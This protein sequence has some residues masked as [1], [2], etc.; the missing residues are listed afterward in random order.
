MFQTILIPLDGTPEA[1]AGLPLATMLAQKPEAKL[2]LL[3]VSSDLNDL[4]AERSARE[5]LEAFAAGL[6]ADGVK[7]ETDF[8][9]GDVAEQIVASAVHHNADLILLT[10]H[11]RHGLLRLWYGSVTED[12]VAKSPIPVLVLR[13]DS[14]SPAQIQTVL[15]PFDDTPGSVAALAIARQIASEPGTA[16]LLARIIPPLPRWGEGW[17]I[18]TDWENT[19]Q[20]SAKAALDGIAAELQSPGRP[21]HTR[22]AVGPI[23]ET[24]T[25]IADDTNADL[26]V[27][28]TRG[29]VGPRR[30]IFGSVADAVVRQAA[31]PVLLVR[32]N[33]ASENT[34]TPERAN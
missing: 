24:I 3:L 30:A 13:A 7:C 34:T 10:T 25:L 27:M 5:Y 29:L 18:N 32:Q 23:A 11:G 31:R 2:V 33:D 28:G 6:T 9:L 1:A 21:V 14:T 20:Q 8:R 19:I 26:I 16:L 17:D 15:V 4:A 22:I 12:V